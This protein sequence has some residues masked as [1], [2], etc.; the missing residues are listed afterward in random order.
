MLLSETECT[1]Q[2]RFLGKGLS[3]VTLAI[4]LFLTSTLALASPGNTVYFAGVAYTSN[5]S[6]VA[7]AFPH[8]SKV[9]SNGGNVALNQSVRQ[10]IQGQSLPET[11]SFDSLGSIK[12]AANSTALALGLDGESTS[13]EHIGDVYKLNVE[14]SAEALFFD[15]K[16][17]QVLGG[18]PFIIDYISVSPTPPSDADIQKAFIGVLTGADGMH[19]LAGEFVKT[20]GQARVPL[21][22][23]K[24][25]RVTSSTLDAKALA[26]L[27][28][29]AP[30][31][32]ASLLPQEIAQ[33][34]GTYL[35]ANQ[36]ISVLPYSSNQALGSSMAARF[37]EGEAYDLKIP[38]ADY[39]IRINVAGFK[40]INQSNS[41]AATLFIYG[42]FVDLT[43]LEPLSNH[44][45]FAQRIKNGETKT[46][47]ASQTNVDDWPPTFDSLKA[48]FSKFTA[49][50]SDP[51]NPWLK[52]G[53]PADP[54]A[55][56]QF[57]SLGE[58]IQSCR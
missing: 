40:K 51:H 13:V 35:A 53:L 37:V 33:S 44:V 10:A 29:Y 8:V 39:D 38:E 7:Q 58:L 18:F 32:D 48:L 20:L 56:S 21:A 27:H 12:D 49:S 28:Q 50:L 24:H 16:E 19:S 9:L 17:K 30:D 5:A 31:V 11:I 46:V 36:H 23:S 15:F 22:S 55:R 26:Y 3:V 57:Q 1:R 52:S 6:N 25:L 45:Y 4:G 34:F 2:V 41:G 42:S 54:Q 14:V 43:V 47:P